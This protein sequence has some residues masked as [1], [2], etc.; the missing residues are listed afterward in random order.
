MGCIEVMVV[1]DTITGRDH[2]ASREM[3][4]DRTR[5]R[6]WRFF[7]VA[8][9]FLYLGVVADIVTTALGFQRAGTRYEQNPA[10]GILIENIG[11]IGL[12]G[13]LT[14]CCILCYVSF[15]IVYF[16]MSLGWSRA[17]NIA[18]VLVLITR[19]LIVAAAV[20]YLIQPS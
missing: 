12:L 4:E 5:Q 2:T 6:R 7:Q 10:G 3:V 11:W 15:K 13:L 17:L 19:W 16:R 8:L 14:A 20:L 9:F 1:S 18:V